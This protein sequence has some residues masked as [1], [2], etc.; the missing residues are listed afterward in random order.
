MCT[1]TETRDL[2]ILLTLDTYQGMTDDEIE[3]LVEYRAQQKFYDREEIH[4]REVETIRVNLEAE[5][6]NT[7]TQSICDVVQSIRDNYIEARASIAPIR[8]P[9]MFAPNITEV[10]NG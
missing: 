8:E 5:D 2:D 7:L 9:E 3:S 1:Q 10:G 4:R 6:R